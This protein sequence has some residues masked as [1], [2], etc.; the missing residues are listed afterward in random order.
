MTVSKAKKRAWDVF[1]KF[2]R[3]RD[4]NY[5]G[6]E[7]YTCGKYYPIEHMHAGHY[8]PGHRAV[9]MFNEI[10]CAAQCPACNIYKHGDPI[11]YREH[12]VRDYG[13]DIVKELEAHRNDIKK[14]KVY[15]LEEIYLKYKALI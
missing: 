13:E 2:I 12:L 7:C 5:L 11:T 8:I 10:N 1:S 14:W 9:N 4:T 15:Q 6:T 3:N